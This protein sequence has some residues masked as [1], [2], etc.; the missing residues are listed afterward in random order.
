MA[1]PMDVEGL[2]SVGLSTQNIQKNGGVTT[3]ELFKQIETRLDSL[4]GTHA[5]TS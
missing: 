5:Q 2:L 4:H 3:I 1:G